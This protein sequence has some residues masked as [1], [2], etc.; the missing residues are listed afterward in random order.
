[1]LKDLQQIMDGGVE[2]A[3]LNLWSSP[4]SETEAAAIRSR[5]KADSN[6]R[7][8]YLG[9][10]EDFADMEGLADDCD[11]RAIAEEP[12]SM[13]HRRNARRVRSLGIA[14][15]VLAAIGAA[16]VIL[17]PW[18]GLDN[19][20]LKHLFTRVGEQR[21]VALEDGSVVTLNTA[22]KLVVDFSETGREIVLEYGEAY[23]EVADD[24][25]RP[26]TVKLGDRSV[27]AIGTAFNVR[28]QPQRYSVA[29]LEGAVS[30]H[31]PDAEIS[32]TPAPVP[33][34]G[35]PVLMTA[36]AQFRVEAGWVAEFDVGGNRIAAFQPASLDRYRDWRTGLLF[37]HREPLSEVV[38]ELNRYSRTKIL[39]EDASVMELNVIVSVR[40]R[41]LDSAL[42]ALEELLPIEVTRH[43]D[44]IVITG[45]NGSGP[46][47]PARDRNIGTND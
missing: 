45:T 38:R 4:F 37:F 20:Y 31:P 8:E 40:V 39:I 9:L 30:V 24:W 6:Y 26:L 25:T 23:F 41:D 29:V 22:T 1:M 12:Q 14:A 27:T 32:S 11:I 19:S 33:A 2:Y 17:S 3:L 15:G 44:R 10:L 42:N 7:D 35:R 28:K 47:P 46:A 18:K 13:I 34:D 16:L 43:Y 36:Q 5:A 21:T